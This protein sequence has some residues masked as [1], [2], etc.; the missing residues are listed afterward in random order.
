M[1]LLE[2]LAPVPMGALRVI[3]GLMWWQRTKR[4][5]K[6]YTW[7]REAKL[8]VGEY[9]QQVL[10]EGVND[11]ASGRIFQQQ[12]FRHVRNMH[13]R[14]EQSRHASSPQVYHMPSLHTDNSK[15]SQASDSDGCVEGFHRLKDA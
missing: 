8:L 9:M 14:R 1:L 15:D 3:K 10:K 11:P 4:Q 13:F 12:F 5:L 2:H 6:R 7:S